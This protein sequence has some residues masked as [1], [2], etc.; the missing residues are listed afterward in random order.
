MTSIYQKVALATIGAVL[1]GLANP[2]AAPAAIVT[3]SGRASFNEALDSDPSWIKTVEGWDT[4]PARTIFPDGSTVNG[5]TY[6]VSTGDA[7]V[8]STGVSLSLPNNLY[9]TEGG[10]TFSPLTDTFTFSFSQPISAFGITFSSTFATETG[11]YLLTT[12]RG[13]VAPSFFDAVAPDF[14]IGQFAGLISDEPFSSVTISGIANALYGLDDLTFARRKDI[15]EPS[16]ML[17][18]L[19]FSVLCVRKAL[20]RR[21]NG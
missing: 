15:P 7:V 11:S 2:K 6:N 1:V 3:F 17:G 4:Y 21:N 20:D 10:S 12:D 5:I 14:P 19:S 18:L 8:V 16:A 9:T 13:D